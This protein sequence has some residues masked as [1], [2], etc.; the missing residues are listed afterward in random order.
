MRGAGSQVESTDDC[1]VVACLI[2]SSCSNS[3]RT[4]LQLPPLPAAPAAQGPRAGAATGSQPQQQQQQQQQGQ[5]SCAPLAARTSVAAALL[6]LL[7]MAQELAGQLGAAASQGSQQPATAG[8]PRWWRGLL[9]VRVAVHVGPLHAAVVG[10]RRPRHRLMGAALQEA[11]Q[12]CA[13]A[14]LNA[15]VATAEAAQLLSRQGVSSLTPLCL[16]VGQQP[17]GASAAGGAANSGSSSSSSCKAPQLW[18][19]GALAAGA[20]RGAAAAAA[21]AEA[22]SIAAVLQQ[23][24]RTLTAVGSHSLSSSASSA[25]RDAAP[26]A[27]PP[28]APRSKGLAPAANGHSSAGVGKQLLELSNGTGGAPQAGALP[29]L[30]H[31]AQPASA[32]LPAGSQLWNPLVP[33]AA[34]A[35]QMLHEAA[36]A[37]GLPGLLAEGLA[38]G[39]PSTRARAA[40]TPPAGQP[41]V[42]GDGKQ[43]GGESAVWALPLQLGAAEAAQ[44][45]VLYQELSAMQ[46]QISVLTSQALLVGALPAALAGAPAPLPPPPLLADPHAAACTGLPAAAGH[47]CSQAASGGHVQAAPPSRDDAAPS[48]A[49]AAPAGAEAR[50]AGARGSSTQRAS[51]FAGLFRRRSKQAPRC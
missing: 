45:G 16:A 51:G 34:A 32:A 17:G 20:Q 9:G 48:G 49:L 4:S 23:A 27:Q 7:Q 33:V 19:V 22:A 24:A 8:P 31:A 37:L 26:A 3:T 29:P 10:R 5:G 15:S 38:P 42:G 30:G 28:G 25:L 40:A 50:L 36:A 44:L 1:L 41:P 13:A 18:C 46:Q 39:A 43:A 47:G 14:P 21:G 2:S 35:P 12:A 11:K 6:Q